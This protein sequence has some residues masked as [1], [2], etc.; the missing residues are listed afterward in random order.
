MRVNKATI[1]LVKE[2]EGYRPEAY[3]DPV[4]VCTIGY[5]TT[6]MAGVGIVP[7]IGMA[8]TKEEA[9]W[10][11]EQAVNNFADMIEPLFTV[12]PNEN[13]FGA[14]VSLSY[15]IGPTAFRKSSAIRHFNLGDKER[16]A[17]SILLWN[18]AGGKVL[19]GLVRRR[20]AEKVLFLTDVPE[21]GAKPPTTLNPPSI[22]A[23]IFALIAKLFGGRK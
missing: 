11:L 18:K 4:G 9:E 15:N 17:K 20:E 10:Y 21:V 2:F 16:A 14:F 19:G 12:E 6:A 1:N 7:V 3:L 22:F 13:E 5:G 23:A 8:I